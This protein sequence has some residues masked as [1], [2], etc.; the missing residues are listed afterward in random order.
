MAK[1]PDEQERLQEHWASHSRQGAVAAGSPVDSPDGRPQLQRSRRGRGLL[2]D[3][4]ARWLIGLGIAATLV[5]SGR[6]GSAQPPGVGQDVCQRTYQVSDVIVTAS[7][8]PVRAVLSATDSDVKPLRRH[9]ISSKCRQ[10]T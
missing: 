3:S 8:A 1:T 5:M 6:Q 10:S 4:A 9:T 2:R 7:G